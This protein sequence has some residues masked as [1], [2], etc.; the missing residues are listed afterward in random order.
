MG[1]ID[2]VVEYFK[3]P[4]GADGATGAAGSN[5]AAGPALEVVQYTREFTVGGSGSGGGDGDGIQ[6]FVIPTGKAFQGVVFLGDKS[7]IHVNPVYGQFDIEPNHP[8]HFEVLYKYN[9]GQPV[10]TLEVLVFVA[11][12]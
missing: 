9:T 7:G 4:A 5:G 10:V 12:A 8:E 6:S 3:G 2:Y 1:F 11:P